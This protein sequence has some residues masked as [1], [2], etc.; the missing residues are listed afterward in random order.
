MKHVFFGVVF[1]CFGSVQAQVSDSVFFS[2]K[3]IL[4]PQLLHKIEKKY[5]LFFSYVDSLVQPHHVTVK[6]KHY[7]LFELLQN[8]EHQTA[9]TF[10]QIDATHYAILPLSTHQKPEKI[11]EVVITYY[12]TKGIRKENNGFSLTSSKNELLPGINGNDILQTLQQFPGIISPHET[13]S[14]LHIRGGTPDQNLVV[15]NDIRIY[16]TG[17]LFGMISP[18]HSTAAQKTNLYSKNIPLRYGERISGV[19]DVVSKSDFRS[20]KQ[21]EAGINLLHADVSVVLPLLPKRWDVVWTARQSISNIWQSPTFDNIAEKVLQN[22]TV[23]PFSR[24]D[25]FNFYDI[26]L[27][28]DFKVNTKNHIAASGMLIYND[29]DFGEDNTKNFN[30]L[31]IYNA[32]L[33]ARWEHHFTSK[34]Q[35]NLLIYGSQYDFFNENQSSEAFVYQKKNRLVD[36]G[37]SLDYSWQWKKEMHLDFGM[38]IKNYDTSHTF[39]VN[40]TWVSFILNAEHLIQKNI[41]SYVELQYH[42]PKLGGHIGYRYNEFFALGNRAEPKVSFYYRWHPYVKTELIWEQKSQILT[43]IRESATNDLSLENNIWTLVDGIRYPILSMNQMSVNLTYQPKKW[44]F[45]TELFYKDVNGITSYSFGFLNEQD[46]KLHQGNSVIKGINTL[47]QYRTLHEQ[48]RISYSFTDAKNRLDNLNNS[49]Y[50]KATT[51]I[52]H[53]LNTAYS[54]SLKNWNFV[55]G[56]TWHSGKPYQML[57]ESGNVDFAHTK[58]VKPY[59]RLDA[60][61]SYDFYFGKN[62]NRNLQIGVVLQNV[63]NRKNTINREYSKKYDEIDQVF[64]NSYT[65]KDYYGL[66]F[67]PNLFLKIEL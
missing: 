32:G 9:L 67:T 48:Y 12:L 56:W 14:G 43:Q 66:R 42:Y 2:E 52:H 13:A 36:S 30:R 8:I 37:I 63:Y 4:L 7:P 21:V 34:F 35:Q 54:K 26:G 31:S 11:K 65:V 55:F 38:Q 10:Q 19:I 59:H 61:G 22:T 57:D 40:S 23:E 44:L 60:T 27:K 45:D 25:R 28:S 62:K 17:H 53:Y 46:H 58:Y 33:S 1:L 47:L 6:P 64:T 50:F 18:F 20:K 29:L 24:N 15:W 41:S 16:H 3:K 49:D 5:T 39:N 51:Q